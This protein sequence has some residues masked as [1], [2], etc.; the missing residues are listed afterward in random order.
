MGLK[1]A[2][3]LPFTCFSC[4]LAK[5]SDKKVTFSFTGSFLPSSRLHFAHS[6]LLSGKERVNH[7]THHSV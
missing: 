7:S 3:S 5:E 1:R 6:L 2:I 4:R